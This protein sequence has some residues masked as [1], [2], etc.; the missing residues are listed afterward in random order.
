[1]PELDS[2]LL[3]ELVDRHGAAL[4]LYARQWCLN[5]DEVVH[6]ALIE[7]AGIG[8]VPENPLAWLFTA[9]RRRAI[10]RLR[11]DRRRQRHEAAAAQR[12]FERRRNQHEAASAAAEA[13]AEL[14]LEDREIVIAHLWGRLTY[15]EIARL[16]GT[17][18]STAQRRYEAAI[19]RLRERMDMPCQKPPV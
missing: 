4:K 6:Q 19:S 17:S 11:G 16:V 1:M 8:T 12:W 18:A 10:S 5:A 2:Q 13:L 14:A 3:A 9:V 7:L 15:E